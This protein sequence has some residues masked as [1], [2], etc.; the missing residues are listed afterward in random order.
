M[1]VAR[2]TR[3]FGAS[4][5]VGAVCLGNST[6]AQPSTNRVTPP[7]AAR[8]LSQATLGANWEEIHRTAE[9]GLAAWL[10]E[11]LRQP[12]GRHQPY[13]DERLNL[14]LEIETATR[15]WA[16]WQ[17]VMESPDAL[18]QR[19][20]LALSEIFVVS[21]GVDALADNPIGLANY[22]DMLLEHS[23]GNYR[24]LLRDVSLHPVMG[25]YLSH[26]RNERSDP[27]RGRYPDENYAREI[28]Q[29]FSVGLF[30]LNLDGTLQLDAGGKPIPTYDNDD[31]TEMAKIFTGLSFASPTAEFRG[32]DAMW[33]RPMRMYEAYHEPGPKQLLR[34]RYVPPGQSGMQDIEAAIDN[35]FQH[36][37]VG[38]FLAR[39]LIQRLVTSNPGPEYIRRV[40]SVF[41]DNGHGV[42]GDLAAIVAAILLDPEARTWPTSTNTT[43]GRLA[44]SYLRRVHLAR[45]FDAASPA[46]EYPID[47]SSAPV[48]FGQRPLSSPTVFN[49]FLPDHQPTGLIADA[50]LYAP[51]FQIL[52]AVTAIASADDLDTQIHRGMNFDDSDF[53]EVRL[54]LS[55]EIVLGS[56]VPAL[57]DRLDLLLLYGHMSGEMRQILIQAVLQLGDPTARA[58]LA[59]YLVALSPEFAVVQ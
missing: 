57:I 3:L 36:P 15:R 18:R 2:S 58:Q 31:I 13:L 17:Q 34:G 42:R 52:T 48:N 29:L 33:T 22:Y 41:R 19:V 26:L 12:V 51:E 54:D 25:V 7:E 49:F 56:N 35:L 43:R 30:E 14:G 50:D 38:P 37:N 6:G 23:F 44:E 20:A 32:G 10:D 5:V 39:R 45:A 28:M 11:Q 40:A 46:R 55:D 47:D 4:L 1:I 24:D 59:T 53:H 21:D 9:I 16:F 27:A 8:F